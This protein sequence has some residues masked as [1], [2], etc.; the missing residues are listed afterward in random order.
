MEMVERIKSFVNEKSV[1]AWNKIR[2][3]KNN[4]NALGTIE[5]V[6]LIAILVALALLFKTFI[7][8]YAG[9]MFEKIESK[10]GEA[11]SDW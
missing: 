10:T 4:I 1:L 2:D 6:L 3:F 11:L 8:K 9:S 7:T 5:V